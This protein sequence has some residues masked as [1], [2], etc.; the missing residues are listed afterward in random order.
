MDEKISLLGFI[1]PAVERLGVP[2]FNFATEC[3]HGYVNYPPING[4]GYATVFPQ[5][6]GLASTFHLNLMHKVG[7]VISNEARALNNWYRSIGLID[8]HTGLTCWAPNLNI[9]R[10]VRWGRFQETYGEDPYLTA[11]MTVA[12]I[13]AL[14]EGDDD[15]YYQVIGTC[16]HYAAYSLDDDPPYNRYDFNAQV[17]SRDFQLTYLPAFR[18]CVSEAKA[19][20]V[21]CRYIP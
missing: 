13:R 8:I 9:A 14:Q 5:A 19:H 6:I 17:S 16:K 11:R 15:R 4:T 18:A 1:S 10:D 7:R 2:A 12:F 21:M 20:S 3:L